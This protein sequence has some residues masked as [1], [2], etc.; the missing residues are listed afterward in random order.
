[1]LS[2]DLLLLLRDGR[3]EFGHRG[4]LLGDVPMLFEGLVAPSAAK[5]TEDKDPSD[6][7]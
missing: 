3:L 2:R 1:L 5:A 7:D 6:P 4:L